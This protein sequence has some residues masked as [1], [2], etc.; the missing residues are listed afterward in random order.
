[1][2]NELEQTYL[3]FLRYILD[4][5]VKKKIVQELVQLVFLVI[6]CDLIYQRVPAV[7]NKTYTVSLNCK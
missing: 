4:H 3:N 2:T 7:Y 1:M 5:G 6:K